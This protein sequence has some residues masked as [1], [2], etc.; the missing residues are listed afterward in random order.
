MS[1]KGLMGSEAGFSGDCVMVMEGAVLVSGLQDA[2]FMVE[3]AVR[4]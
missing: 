4:R 3:C 2:E 1:L